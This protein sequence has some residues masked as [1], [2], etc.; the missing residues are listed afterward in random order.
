MLVGTSF[1]NS[2]PITG[3]ISGPKRQHLV[4][5][6]VHGLDLAVKLEW[7]TLGVSL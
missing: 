3:L 1:G 4:H 5:L 2:T 6:N 7:A